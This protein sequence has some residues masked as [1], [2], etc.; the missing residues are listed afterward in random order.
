[1]IFLT[2]GSHEPYDR[3]VS[4]VDKWCEQHP[5]AELFGQITDKGSYTP[6]HFKWT[7]YLGAKDYDAACARAAFFVAHAGMGSII[8][9]LTLGKPIVIMPRRAYLGEMRNDHQVA[10]MAQFRDRPLVFAAEDEG[11]LLRQIDAARSAEAKTG[12]VL[13]PFAQPRLIRFLKAEIEKS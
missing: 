9:A 12:A 10:T 1:M 3:L 7:P 5:D 11:S 6:R 13:P 2:I 4:A 8:T